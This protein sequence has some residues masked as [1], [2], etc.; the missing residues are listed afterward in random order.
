[1]PL[2]VLV[3]LAIYNQHQQLSL[4]L[5]CKCTTVIYMLKMCTYWAHV[6]VNSLDCKLLN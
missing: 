5:L 3:E 6:Y 1:M 4:V 2:N